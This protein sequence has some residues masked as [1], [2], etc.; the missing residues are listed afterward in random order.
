MKDRFI[1]HRAEFEAKQGDN[2]VDFKAKLRDLLRIPII[3]FDGKM[4]HANHPRSNFPGP[5]T[6]CRKQDRPD[7][8]LLDRGTIFDT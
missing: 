3:H 5:E 6:S 7:R 1:V 2:L 4:A 8:I